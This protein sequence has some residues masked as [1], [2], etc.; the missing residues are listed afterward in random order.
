V[1]ELLLVF[2]ATRPEF[3]TA[4]SCS[5]K[6]VGPMRR[7]LMRH[8]GKELAAHPALPAHAARLIERRLEAGEALADFCRRCGRCEAE[9]KAEAENILG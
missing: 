6:L 1:D 9:T 4:K 3:E 5:R 7:Y 2:I 8:D